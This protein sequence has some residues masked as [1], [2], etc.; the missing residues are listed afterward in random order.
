VSLAMQV[1]RTVLHDSD[2][3][4]YLSMMAPR[5]VELHRGLKPAGSIYLHPTVSPYLKMLMGATF[6][7]GSFRNEITWQRSTPKGPVP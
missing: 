5:L 7:P 4:A 1:F 6:G 2:M 3:L